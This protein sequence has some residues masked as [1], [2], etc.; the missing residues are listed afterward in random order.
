MFGRKNKALEQ[1]I[2]EL[3]QMQ[4]KG[5]YGGN[6]NNEYLKEVYR[7]VYQLSDFSKTD[8]QRLMDY[9]TYN[10]VVRGLLGTQIGDTIAELS[11]YIE[12]VDS[13]KE[14]F[15]H[16]S[17][18]LLN[19][20]N[21]LDSKKMFLKGWSVYYNVTGMTFTY[22][23]NEQGAK[24]RISS[25]YNLPAHKMGIKSEGWKKPISSY[26]LEGSISDKLDPTNTMYIREFNPDNDSLFGLSPLLAAARLCELLDIS[27]RRQLTAISNG[28]VAGVVTPKADEVGVTPDQREEA[29][30]KFNNL[31]N[32]NKNVFLPIGIEY[33][34]MGSTPADLSVLETSKNAVT[35]LSFVYGIPIDVFYGQSK[36]ENAKE[37]KKTIITQAALPR[38]NLFLES[39]TDRIRKTDAAF[40]AKGGKFIVNTDKIDILKNSPMDSMSLLDKAGATLNE[41]REYLGYPKIK[42][43]YADLPI[44]PLGVSLGDPNNFDINENNQ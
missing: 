28:A 18:D 8:N 7:Y 27:D 30:R 15:A 26:L 13:N 32:T 17:M 16:W 4:K 39:F 34:K 6:E 1:R 22:F 24:R 44:I 3:E 23:E 40:N 10:A 38:L 19:R 11:D 31:E 25:M 35:A 12:L 9:Y 33:I 20:P 2:Q 29:E 43:T 21:D 37:A 14:T 42:F 5:Y 41:R 36:Y